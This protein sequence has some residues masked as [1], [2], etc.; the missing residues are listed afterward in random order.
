MAVLLPDKVLLVIIDDFNVECFVLL[1]NKADT[2][3]GIDP[4][5]EL[6]LAIAFQCFQAISARH[7]KVCQTCRKGQVLQ[8][9]NCNAVNIGRD[10]ATM[11][12]FEQLLRL[13][14]LEARDHYTDSND[15][16]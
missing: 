3:S 15:D 4:D 10:R 9:S 11:T 1:P 6:P 5:A 12:R 8:L 7:L 14:I 16:R 2:I 13:R